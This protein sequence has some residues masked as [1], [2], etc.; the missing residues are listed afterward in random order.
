MM[1]MVESGC[2]RETAFGQK[3]AFEGGRFTNIFGRKLGFWGVAMG[4]KI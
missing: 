3:L 2:S 1:A 4:E